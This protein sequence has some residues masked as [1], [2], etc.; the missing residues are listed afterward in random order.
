MIKHNKLTK[1]LAIVL[2][3][4]LTVNSCKKQVSDPFDIDAVISKTELQLEHACKVVETN[5]KGKKILPR[6]IDGD[7]VIMV[8]S[9]DWTSGFFPGE[10]WMMYDLTGDKK[11]KNKAIQYTELLEKEQYNTGTHDVG[12]MMYCSYGHGYR[13]TGNPEYKKILIQ[14]AKSLASR[15][16]DTIKCTRSWDHN[17]KLYT[18]PVIIDNMMNMELLLWASKETGDNTFKDIALN[19][20]N[21]TIKNHFRKDNSSYHVVDYSPETGE[22]I[23]KV[24]NQGFADES[25][26]ARGQAWGLYGYT[27]MY[28]E[29]HDPKY[30]DQANKIAQV[31]LSYD[32]MPEDNIPYWD[33]HAPNIPNEPRDASAAAITASALYELSTH[34]KTNEKTYKEAADKII[35]TLSTKNYLVKVGEKQGFLLDHSTGNWPRNSELD[36][37]I[38]YADY[39]FLE[40]LKRKKELEGIK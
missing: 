10:L 21:T 27:V 3:L 13:T 14:T 6:S 18:Y 17:P 24:T 2:L 16:N 36:V 11:W 33:M 37:P 31:V 22:V 34:S 1:N 20:A 29:T 32:K 38:V 12:F 39:Y 35:E 26:W 40:A 5:T 28:R 23:K 19:H 4:A 7:R 15:Y 8:S 25:I 9:S 30:L